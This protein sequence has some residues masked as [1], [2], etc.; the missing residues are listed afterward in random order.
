MDDELETLLSAID[1]HH[2]LMQTLRAR[3][4]GRRVVLTSPIINRQEAP[5][6]QVYVAKGTMGT[7]QDVMFSTSTPFQIRFP[8]FPHKIA[9][10][11]DNIQ[12]LP[13]TT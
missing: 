11:L 9:V 12:V 6:K 1:A 10:L 3:W 2:V 8:G 4:V 5:G 13:R 7:I